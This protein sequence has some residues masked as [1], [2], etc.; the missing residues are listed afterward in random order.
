[1]QSEETK[2]K[3]KPLCLT[4]MGCGGTGKSVLINIVV[5]YIRKIFQSNNS[6]LVTAPTGAAAHNVGG[7]TIHREFKLKYKKQRNKLSNTAKKQLMEKL[8]FT[9]ALVFDERSMISQH[10]LG[11]AELNIS[12]TAHFGGHET[13]D[14]GGI[15]VVVIFGDDYQLPPPG[16]NGAID[17]LFNQ[18]STSQS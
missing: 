15:P 7:Q 18:G 10:V 6:V 1:M 8:M 5:G 13:E 17:A 2:K 9:I 14:W 16:T 12:T 3:F 4:V 11:S